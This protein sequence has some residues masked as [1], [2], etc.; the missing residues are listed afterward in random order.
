MEL[1][2]EQIRELAFQCAGAGASAVMRAAPDAVMPTEEATR[3]VESILAD[4]GV[5]QPGAAGFSRDELRGTARDE[6]TS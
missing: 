3:A 2:V 4:F 6:A 5:P 1:T